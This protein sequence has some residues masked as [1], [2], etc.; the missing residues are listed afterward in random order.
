MNNMYERNKDGIKK[1]LKEIWDYMKLNQPL[2]K[3]DLI[4]GCGCANLDIPVK[5]SNLLK[6]GY[7][8]KILFAGGLG[9]ITKNKFSKSEAEIYKDIAIKN[10]IKENDILIET[11]STN[12]SDNFRFAL[13]VLKKNN[14]RFDKILIVHNPFS[15]RRT[16]SA[17]KAVFPNK[18][19]IIT[20]SDIT[21]EEY[22]NG[23]NNKSLEEIINEISVIVGD[24][25][26]IIIYPQF[27]WQIENEVPE[28]V[29][30]A[31]YHLKKLGFSKYILSKE[32]IKETIHKYGLAE[33]QSENYF[34]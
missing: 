16:F 25:Q 21:F 10:G 32:Q 28:S 11:Q 2:E 12:T 24:I 27:G 14:F 31:Y 29:R 34:C 26:R 22:F 33:G 7:A 6:A 15:E 18:H 8:S 1:S 9:K 3:C 5:C 17:A 30:K 23:L 19:L 4:I 13:Q 20:S